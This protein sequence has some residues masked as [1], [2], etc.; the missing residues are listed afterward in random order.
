MLPGVKLVDQLAKSLQLENR[1][2]ALIGNISPWHQ[3]PAFDPLPRLHLLTSHPSYPQLMEALQHP[4]PTNV[5]EATTA[6]D[7]IA[8]LLEEICP[9]LAV[10]PAFYGGIITH[11]VR[12]AVA[13]ELT[14]GGFPVKF[15]GGD[16]MKRLPGRFAKLYLDALRAFLETPEQL[17]TERPIWFR[18]FAYGLQGSRLAFLHGTLAITAHIVRD[19]PEGIS[20]TILALAHDARPE[21]PT[22]ELAQWILD[23]RNQGNMAWLRTLKGD[24]DR[25]DRLL[26]HYTPAVLELFANRGDPLTRSILRLDQLL[27]TDL[28]GN[29]PIVQWGLGII[30]QARAEAWDNTIRLLRAYAEPIGERREYQISQV[31]ADLN[32]SSE[33]LGQTILAE[34]IVIPISIEAIKA[35]TPWLGSLLSVY[36]GD[37]LLS[38]RGFGRELTFCV[39]IS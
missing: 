28:D 19:L 15:E 32:R 6:L 17:K 27:G 11:R 20:L 29:G 24:H 26:T 25:I 1:W 16:F 39:A 34:R 2:Q 30:A 37:P 4:S 3:R 18:T 36:A 35:R 5:D 10:F 7:Q 14:I 8:E 33:T 38:L 9:P 31:R 13:G 22:H 12:Q 23:I 21:L